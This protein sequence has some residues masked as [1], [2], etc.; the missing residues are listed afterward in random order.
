M[1]RS[2]HKCLFFK[3]MNVRRRVSY[4]RLTSANA[5]DMT[6]SLLSHNSKHF[7]SFGSMQNTYS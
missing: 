3:E 2:S 6:S 1:W 7:K 5:L 4:D